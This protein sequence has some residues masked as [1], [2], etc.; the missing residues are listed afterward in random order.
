MNDFNRNAKD[1]KGLFKIPT[2]TKFEANLY[3]RICNTAKNQFDSTN[4]ECYLHGLV[5]TEAEQ[6]GN[7]ISRTNGRYKTKPMPKTCEGMMDL[8]KNKV[9]FNFLKSLEII[10]IN[11]ETM[12]AHP[13]THEFWEEEEI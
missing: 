13:S 12:L 2:E 7:W 9:T 8:N 11:N 5:F 4:G 3:Q 6:I 1:L 10:H